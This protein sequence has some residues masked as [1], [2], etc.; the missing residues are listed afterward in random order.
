METNVYLFAALVSTGIFLL[1]FVLS[2]FVGSMDTDIDVNTDGNA[3]L[4]MSSVLSFKGL[5]HFC[6]G[7]GWFMYLCPVP[8]TPLHYLGAFV[9]GVFF[10]LILAWIYKLCYKLKQENKP[11]K[12]QDLIG[13]RCEIYMCPKESEKNNPDYVVYIAIN[14]AQRELA[15]KS[16]GRKSY[17]EGD[18]LTLKDYKDGIYYID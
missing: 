9:S 15:V 6:M 17:R 1:Q 2:V 13:R 8:Y 5:I 3:D 11:E 14:G 16:A 12:G 7:F 10:V 18:I 4:D